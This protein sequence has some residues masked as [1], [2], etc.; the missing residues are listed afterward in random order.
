MINQKE[1]TMSTKK[2]EL[3]HHRSD[4]IYVTHILF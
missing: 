3:K 4:K 1:L 2:L